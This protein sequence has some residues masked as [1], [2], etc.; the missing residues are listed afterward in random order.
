MVTTMTSPKEYKIHFRLHNVMD[1]HDELLD[2]IYEPG[3]R[4][5]RRQ[6]E[7]HVGEQTHYTKSIE[8]T[9]REIE[10]LR[11][12]ATLEK[13]TLDDTIDFSF[14]MP[15]RNGFETQN[16]EGLRPWLRNHINDIFYYSS[17]TNI[18][19]ECLNEDVFGTPRQNIYQRV[20]DA[21]RFAYQTP[22]HAANYWIEHEF[23]TTLTNELQP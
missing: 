12:T 17:L 23:D 15:H 3:L 18:L 7:T 16:S 2:L 19:N 20:F 8:D 10:A 9:I 4:W 22:R 14:V 6:L 1:L 21:F 13:N 11:K 5:Y